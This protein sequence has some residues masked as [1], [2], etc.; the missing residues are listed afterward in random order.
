MADRIVVMNQGAVEQ[1]GTPG[2]IYGAP[3]SLF[4]ARF[5]GHMNFIAAVADG[6]PGRARLGA[7][8]LRHRPGPAVAPGGR[9][10]LGI[11][12]EEIRIGPAA[13]GAE[14]RLAARVLGIQFQ[15]ALTRLVLSAGE[16]GEITLECDLPAAALTELG[17]KEGSDVPLALTAEALR[18]FVEPT[19]GA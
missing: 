13:D 6:R 4:V 5:V 12:P 14:N 9:L 7:T 18:V 1:I 16:A 15:G 3:A 17:L 11:R 8:T 19:A 2:E 10:T